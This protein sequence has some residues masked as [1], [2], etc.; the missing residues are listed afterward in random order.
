VLVVLEVRQVLEVPQGLTQYL[1]QS[2]LTAA[3]VEVLQAEA[4]RK[5]YLAVLAVEQA[6]LVAVVV[7]E[8]L[9]KAMQVVQAQ[10]LTSKVA[11]VVLVE[12]VELTQVV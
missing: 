10:E 12:L 7:L 3:A 5:V 2:H 4:F 9:I 11:V 6:I 1:P 8:L